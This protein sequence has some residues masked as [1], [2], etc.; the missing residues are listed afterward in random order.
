MLAA[1]TADGDDI[2][3]V[4]FAILE[5]LLHFLSKRGAVGLVRQRPHIEHLGVIW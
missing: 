5:Y 1:L 3:R 2:G 4:S